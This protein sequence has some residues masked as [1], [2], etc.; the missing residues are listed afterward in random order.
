M[1]VGPGVS[2]GTGIGVSVAVAVSVGVGVGVC[3]A[4]AVKVGTRLLLGVAAGA[5]CPAISEP[6][7]QPNVPS[8]SVATSMMI[9]TVLRLMI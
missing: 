1:A 8:P 3:V 4:V 9:E 7:E 6:K 2:V 5:T